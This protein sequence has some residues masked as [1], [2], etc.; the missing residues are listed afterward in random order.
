ML[1]ITTD[2]KQVQIR[3][4]LGA[5]SA[6]NKSSLHYTVSEQGLSLYML[7][8]RES[9]YFET[10]ANGITLNGEALTAENA[11][12]KLSVLFTAG[13][14]GSND[15]STL[16]NKPGINNVELSGNKTSAELGLASA[17]DLKAK[18]NLYIPEVK[19]LSKIPLGENL[20]GMTLVF[21]T[22][23]PL[24]ITANLMIQLN[25]GTS[26]I[27]TLEVNKNYITYLEGVTTTLYIDDEW[28]LESFTFPDDKDYIVTYKSFGASTTYIP[29]VA[30]K[31]QFV[32]DIK[33]NY[34]AIQAITSG[35]QDKAPDDGKLYGLRNG[36]LEEITGGGI[37]DYNEL[38]NR[39]VLNGAILEGE[40]VI[41]K[42]TVGLSSVD[43][44]SDI[45]KPISTAT[46]EALLN[47]Y[48][49][50]QTYSQE[51]VNDL[52]A[53]VKKFDAVEVD[54]L[55]E[56][57]ESGII[58]LVPKEPS[59]FA[60]YIWLE[61]QSKFEEFGD[62][63]VNLSDYY[64][65][66]AV[67]D[68]LALKVDT[69]KVGAIT[70][71]GF[72]YNGEVSTTQYTTLPD[73]THVAIN[74][75]YDVIGRPGVTEK[76]PY[77]EL[78][79]SGNGVKQHIMGTKDGFYYTDNESLSEG[80]NEEHKL[81]KKGEINSKANLYPYT[82]KITQSLAKINQD[83]DIMDIDFSNVVI[84]G[85]PL[86][87]YSGSM[88][89]SYDYKIWFGDSYLGYCIR[90]H[91]YQSSGRYYISVEFGI[92]NDDDYTTPLS[93]VLHTIV[94]SSVDGL[95]I[96]SDEYTLPSDCGKIF[97]ISSIWGLD[98]AIAL[99]INLKLDITKNID[100]KDCWLKE[101]GDSSI[102]VEYEEHNFREYLLANPNADLSGANIVMDTSSNPTWSDS[103]TLT[104][105]GGRFAT[106]DGQTPDFPAQKYEDSNT[107]S[108]IVIG[109]QNGGWILPEIT[110]ADDF[111]KVTYIQTN[112][113]RTDT[114][115]NFMTLRIPKTRVGL[116][117]VY[118][119]TVEN[120]SNIQSNENSI[121]NIKQ[122]IVDI[123]EV[124]VAHEGRLDN[125]D[126]E[127]ISVN[128]NKANL[129]KIKS[130]FPLKQYLTDNPTADLSGC[131]LIFD[132][133]PITRDDF[134]GNNTII[135][136]PNGN[137]GRLWYV[138]AYGAWLRASKDGVE[139]DIT[140][141]NNNSP[142]EYSWNET[143]FI[144]SDNFGV[145]VISNLNT[146]IVD[147]I[148]IEV[149]TQIVDVEDNHEAIDNINTEIN[150]LTTRIETLETTIG[151]I[152]TVLDTINGEVV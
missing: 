20:R 83:L 120:A 37:S 148:S 23:T 69:H 105:E 94:F 55:P 88:G 13:G 110:L 56:T 49:K 28:Q 62:S 141:N 95:N 131:K 30:T 90:F 8:S 117:E 51:E 82:E 3:K 97:K 40:V 93:S 5:I 41:D 26:Y 36:A 119:K 118:E 74:T 27:R 76:E 150:S 152:N 149:V 70:E 144:L 16:S 103:L 64:N 135:E 109:L 44:T 128:K 43:N 35:K 21:D 18:A 19:E 127:F 108:T 137:A 145:P 125:H 65:K 142:V 9:S 22:N 67:D 71:Q 25:D 12:E 133:L 60:E 46:Q 68:K 80:Y 48:L 78:S 140:H 17:T 52:L 29:F 130:V 72:G 57:G 139:T 92:S 146:T 10:F 87:I 1:T 61:S 85:N 124:D 14:D 47:Y 63:D 2:N 89:N 81:A 53:A 58:Y 134:S 42:N 115:V 75:G 15:Y 7:N 6:Y 100:V 101:S 11:S 113:N 106:Y 151:D 132:G 86:A 33:Q 96:N 66:Q 24:A 39:P 54:V 31:Y 77:L 116:K 59:G 147:H 50:T 114:P 79:L 38:R 121:E 34:Q 102:V 112:L 73:G 143:E 111:G 122:S 138:N 126:N 99:Y 32:I 104:A 4:D 84:S 123:Q 129:Y 107:A 136:S 45:D 98:N 91:S